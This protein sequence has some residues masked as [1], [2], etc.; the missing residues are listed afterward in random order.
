MTDRGPLVACNPEAAEPLQAAEEPLAELLR[1]RSAGR[2]WEQSAGNWWDLDLCQM[3]LDEARQLIS[4]A[5]N[6]QWIFGACL[7]PVVSRDSGPGQ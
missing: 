5:P 1:C 7:D 2:T 6:P 4:Q 3:A